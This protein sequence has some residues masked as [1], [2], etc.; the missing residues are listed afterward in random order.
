[1]LN[2]PLHRAHLAMGE[3]QLGL[4]WMHLAAG[5]AAVVGPWLQRVLKESRPACS[6]HG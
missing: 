2:M 5:A 3:V 1:M 6:M 4:P